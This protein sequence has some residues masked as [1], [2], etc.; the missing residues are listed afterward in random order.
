MTQLE[1]TLDVA[2]LRE[3]YREE[4]DLRLNVA[5]RADYITLD[6]ELADRYDTDLWAPT[7]GAR[8]PVQ[9][10]LEVVIVG[11]G[12]GGLLAA[13]NLR[14]H[15]VAA[16]EMCI[17]E[18]ASDFGGTWYWNR[19][20][21]LS[22][23]TEAYVYLPLLEETGYIPR[24]KYAKGP[25]ILEHAQRIGRHFGL[26]EQALFQTR[27]TDAVWS[28]DEQRWIISTDR[29]DT[30]RARYF[31]LCGGATNRPKLPGIP[32]LDSFK[33][34][35]FHT[36]RWEYGYTGGG[37]TGNLDKLKDKRVGLIGT[38]CS[39]IQSVPSLG[40]SAKELYVF[41]RTP[42]SVNVRANRPTDPEWAASLQP[43]WQME[44]MENFLKIVSGEPQE[45]DLVADAWTWNFRNVRRVFESDQDNMESPEDLERADFAR[46][47][48]VRARV[49]QTVKDPATAAALKPWYG[50][51]C[52]RPT[53]HDSYL[54]TF[55]RPNVTMVDTL[56]AGVDRITENGVVANG[57][58]YPLDCIIFATGFDTAAGLMK[59]LGVDPVGA[60]GIRLSERWERDF[61]SLHG[62]LVSDFPNMFVIG[63]A[64]GTLA[65]TRTYDLTIQTEHCAQIVEHCR[66]RQSRRVEAR[67]EAE[68]AWKAEMDDK[69]VDL[70][71]YFEACTPGYINAEG[72]GT[73]VWTYFYGAGPVAYRRA[74][75][76]WRETRV[77]E[78]LIYDGD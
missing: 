11:G 22:C 76:S 13:G 29:G 62:M 73:F 31:F 49:D 63:G 47:E 58:E 35:S 68:R 45:V 66:E 42:S 39:T 8:E 72:K 50:V 28:E 61:S 75:D 53:F 20:P 46:M 6:G 26:Y 32:G 65:T 4:R 10:D 51:L 55:N 67:P 7:D 27:I 38:G 54:D 15:G 56:G 41:Q 14:K 64:Q 48:E 3:R 24:E 21:G 70:K 5:G 43:G 52:K 2:Q 19:Y 59:N 23:D 78:D 40:E 34:H 12:F 36:M 30:L 1:A 44:R 57:V 18:R 37:P 17:I 77:D 71:D 25:E 74:I 16:S 60:G 33:G 69:A 9:T